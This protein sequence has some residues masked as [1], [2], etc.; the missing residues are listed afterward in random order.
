MPW[1]FQF[2]FYSCN[3]FRVKNNALNFFNF[4]LLGNISYFL[5]FS[6]LLNHFLNPCGEKAISRREVRRK[7]LGVHTSWIGHFNYVPVRFWLSKVIRCFVLHMNPT[8]NK[9]TCIHMHFEGLQKI[10]ELQHWCWW[11]LPFQKVERLLLKCEPMKC[12]HLIVSW[13]VTELKLKTKKF[14]VL[15][16]LAIVII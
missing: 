11:Q 6:S 15:L 7:S 16:I 13:C 2:I 5:N 10:S 9:P 3:F 12:E 4:K 8:S 1:S 14:N